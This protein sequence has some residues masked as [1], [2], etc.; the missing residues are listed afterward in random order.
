MSDRAPTFS[1]LKAKIQ[2]H[3][4]HF[5]PVSNV[6]IGSNPPKKKAKNVFT[7][8]NGRQLARGITFF[9]KEYGY[10]PDSFGALFGVTGNDVVKWE[11]TACVDIW[12]SR[13][14]NTI[15]SMIRER[16]S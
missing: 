11:E 3:E 7:P 10:T 2:A 15:I 4:K 16:K 1:E 6:P 9:R 13:I 5:K 14:A 12:Q 8:A